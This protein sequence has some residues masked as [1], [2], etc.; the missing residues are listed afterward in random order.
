MLAIRSLVRFLLLLF[1]PCVSVSLAVFLVD[2]KRE[3]KKDMVGLNQ[4]IFIHD[5]FNF[6]LFLDEELN[7]KMGMSTQKSPIF[8][9]KNH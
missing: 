9:Y 5:S 1:R 3:L 2:F 8:I 7:N 4:Q 6:D